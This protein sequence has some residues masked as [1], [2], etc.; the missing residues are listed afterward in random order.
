MRWIGPFYSI[1][2]EVFLSLQSLFSLM[3]LLHS[4]G[5]NLF[6]LSMLF[7]G[8]DVFLLYILQFFFGDVTFSCPLPVPT[9]ERVY[10]I[11]LSAIRSFLFSGFLSLVVHHGT[12]NPASP[13]HPSH[14]KREFNFPKS[15]LRRKRTETPKLHSA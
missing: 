1:F 8:F 2:Q 15:P 3:L 14:K 10:A 4:Y 9:E 5:K 13:N 11:S 7:H 12:A 6:F